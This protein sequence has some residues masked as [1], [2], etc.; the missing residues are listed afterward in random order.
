MFENLLNDDTNTTL[1]KG[2]V[3]MSMTTILIVSNAKKGFTN[4]FMNFIN[5]ILIEHLKNTNN[6]SNVY[7]RQI[8]CYC[9]EELETEY[10]L[11][12]FCLM[13][14][15]TI[16]LLEIREND[17]DEKASQRSKITKQSSSKLPEFDKKIEL[18]SM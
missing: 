8:C 9:L 11:I 18:G 2:Q 15:K 10:P 16:E 1:L 5:N 12:L 7:L 4:V 6:Y 17:L 13:G 14:K 3:L